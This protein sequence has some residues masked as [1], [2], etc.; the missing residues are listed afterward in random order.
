MPNPNPKIENLT[1]AGKG[2][3]KLNRVRVEI[4][5]PPSTLE[6]IDRYVA[7]TGG[8]RSGAIEMAIE[9]AIGE[10]LD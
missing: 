5:L 10:P 3:P 1:N 2:R 7:V 8:T 9:M 4:T 6:K